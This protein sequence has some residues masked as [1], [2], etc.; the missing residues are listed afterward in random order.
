MICTVNR[1]PALSVARAGLTPQAF[2][3][4]L[5]RS[6]DIVRLARLVRL[7]P[8]AAFSFI[9]NQARGDR[10][11]MRRPAITQQPLC[12]LQRGTKTCHLWSAVRV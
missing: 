4:G 6:T 1:D 7:V 12:L 9:P 2:T 3:S 5:A 10:R 8:E 11:I